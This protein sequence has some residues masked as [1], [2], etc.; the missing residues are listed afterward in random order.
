MTK[1]EKQTRHT[2]RTGFTKT[3]CANWKKGGKGGGCTVKKVKGSCHINQCKDFIDKR[4][5]I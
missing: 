2:K 5:K 1:P 4:H 3:D